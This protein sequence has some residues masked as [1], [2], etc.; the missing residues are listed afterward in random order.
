MAGVSREEQC[1][2]ARC[3]SSA[4]Q[5]STREADWNRHQ[6]RS[7]SGRRTRTSHGSQGL[8]RDQARRISFA[9]FSKLHCTHNPPLDRSPHLSS[10]QL[11]SPLRASPRIAFF[12]TCS[13]S[14]QQDQSDESSLSASIRPRVRSAP[15]E[16]IRR[17]LKTTRLGLDNIN[18][19]TTAVQPSARPIRPS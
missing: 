17:P 19:T 8:G 11:S 18:L 6:S 7:S 3:L 12:S 13:R 9:P 5:M 10:N 15:S 4:V 16:V 14:G 1:H 2:A